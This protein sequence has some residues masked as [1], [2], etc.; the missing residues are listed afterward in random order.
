MFR[1]SWASQVVLV[2][3]NLPANAQ[4]QEMWVQSLGWQDPLWGHGDPLQDSCLQ[5]PMDR[6]AWLAVVHGVAKGQTRLRTH[7]GACCTSCVH[8][9]TYLS[10]WIGLGTTTSLTKLFYFLKFFCA[11]SPTSDPAWAQLCAEG[12]NTRHSHNWSRRFG[13]TGRDHMGSLLSMWIPP[14]HHRLYVFLASLFL[15]LLHPTL[16][17]SI[18]SVSQK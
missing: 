3:K 14:Q 9:V 5:N 16:W 18:W 11:A 10:L 4:T 8:V 17:I 1:R 7:I 13:G 12:T 2:V 6:R 15:P